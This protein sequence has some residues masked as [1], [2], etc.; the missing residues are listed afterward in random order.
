MPRSARSWVLPTPSPGFVPRW[1][2]AS[3]AAFARLV[4]AARLQGGVILGPEL[5]DVPRD[6]LFYSGGGGT[7]RGQPYRSLGVLAPLGSGTD[8]LVGGR[9]FVGGSLELRGKVTDKIGVVGFLDAGSVGIDGF[10]GDSANSH[11]GAGL[12]VR[13]DTTIGPIRVDVAAPV[14]GDTGDGVQFYIGLGQAF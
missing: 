13:Y 5:L 12:G 9:Y 6:Q 1:T 11:A 10:T 2:A 3:T 8:F 14:S 7:V 4:V